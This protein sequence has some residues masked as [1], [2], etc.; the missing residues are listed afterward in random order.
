MFFAAPDFEL[1]LLSLFFEFGLATFLDDFFWV[2][3]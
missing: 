2:W 3:V 1:A